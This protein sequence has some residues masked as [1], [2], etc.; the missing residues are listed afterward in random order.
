MEIESEQTPAVRELEKY[1]DNY[2]NLARRV[3][4]GIINDSIPESGRQAASLEM[5]EAMKAFEEKMLKY[6]EAEYNQFLATVDGTRKASRDG[7]RS[8]LIIGLI[9]A[10]ILAMA[11]ILVGRLINDSIAEVAN[12]LEEIA[13]GEGDLTRRLSTSSTDAIGRLVNSFNTFMDKLHGIIRDVTNS[14]SQLATAA[15]EMSSIS[16]ESNEGVSKQQT[17]TAQVASAMSEMSSSVNEVAQSAEA[18]ANAAQSASEEAFSGSRVVQNTV[19]AINSLAGEVEGAA[20][21]IKQLEVD[22]ENI[23]GVLEVIRGI[24]EQTNLLAL[25]AAIEAARAGEQG[26]GFA[27]VADEVRTLA[28]RTNESTQEI[29]AM[30]ER[31]QSGTSQAVQVMNKGREQAE[32]SVEQAVKAGD[33]L[34][35][36]TE[37]AATINDMNNQISTS[38]KEQGSVASEINQSISV[39][40][41]IGEQ[42]SKGAQRTA[43]ASQ[44]MAELASQLQA[45]VGRFRV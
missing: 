22:S 38:A 5:V 32:I 15:R 13:T 31:L 42:T 8:S 43:S 6:R 1:F 20:K 30:I 14:T 40:S 7:T 29:Q 39:I 33:S 44:E 37:S 9:M 27:V 45:L 21:V 41:E 35:A 36:I 12:S 28:K 16:L 2:Y 24:S 10:L 25:N 19:S 4:L 26:R 23:G 3:T 17:R 34:E 11:V 18:A